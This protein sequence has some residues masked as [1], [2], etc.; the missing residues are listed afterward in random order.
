MMRYFLLLVFF[1]SGI[2]FANDMVWSKTGHRVVGEVAQDYLSKK[3]KR[4]IADLLNGQSLAAVA[5]FADEIKS[6]RKYSKFSAWHYVNMPAD[7]SYSETEPSEYGDIVQGI[8]TCLDILKDK[9]SARDDKVF[10]LKLLIHLIGDLH[11]PMHVGRAEDKGG[12]DIQ[13]QWFNNGT[14]LHR[15]WDSNMIDDYGMSFSELAT[16]LPVLSKQQVAHLQSGTLLDWVAETQVLANKVYDSV[17]VGEKL[18]YQ[19]S[20]QWWNTVETQLQKGGIRLAVV[21]NQAFK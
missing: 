9:N 1:W 6:D 7:K 18:R 12:N 20:Y 13:L 15:V 16:E 3:A 14:N 11:Q 21:L 8:N 17:E 4:A 5:N 19:Y 10:Y 2:S